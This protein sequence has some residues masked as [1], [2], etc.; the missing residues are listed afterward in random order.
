MGE[1]VGA[2]PGSA[3]PGEGDRTE[4]ASSTRHDTVLVVVVALFLAAGVIGG[5]AVGWLDRGAADRAAAGL[6]SAAGQSE[7]PGWSEYLVRFTADDQVAVGITW[8]E[9]HPDLR[10]VG[11]S[12][13][14]RTVRVGVRVPVGTALD[15]LEAQSFV[16]FTVRNLPIFFCH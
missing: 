7:T 5:L 4:D 8:I 10:F 6:A 12:I 11:D 1:P 2:A 14:P 9:A 3:R 15:A 13:Y 16:S